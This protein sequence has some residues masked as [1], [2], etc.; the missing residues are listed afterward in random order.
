MKTEIIKEE[1]FGNHFFLL[2][3][4]FLVYESEALME[5]ELNQKLEPLMLF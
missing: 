5:F 3:G 2:F 1:F 4:I